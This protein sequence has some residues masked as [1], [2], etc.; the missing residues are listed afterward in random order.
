MTGSGRPI[1]EMWPLRGPNRS[2]GSAAPTWS[3]STRFA[4][5][6]AF[7][8]E[9]LLGVMSNLAPGIP[10]ATRSCAPWNA[11][12]TFTTS[13]RNPS[14]A[15]RPPEGRNVGSGRPHRAYSLRGR[16]R[17]HRFSL[18]LADTRNGSASAAA[19][20]PTSPPWASSTRSSFLPVR[21]RSNGGGQ[22]R[23]TRR[24]MNG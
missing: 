21:R 5:G 3:W 2:T 14:T 19:P 24:S 1:L 17:S 16:A 15:R 6:V 13:M 10:G 22:S 8:V 11:V 12:W 7:D 18:A 23:T 4:L 9:V 20:S